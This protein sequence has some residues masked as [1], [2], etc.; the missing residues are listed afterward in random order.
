[1]GGRV[2]AFWRLGTIVLIR[3]DLCLRHMDRIKGA[4]KLRKIPRARSYGELLALR[5]YQYCDGHGADP[6]CGRAIT[7]DIIWG[8]IDAGG[9]GKL[10]P[11]HERQRPSG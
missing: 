4:T 10:W 8:D 2:G 9:A 7:A 3:V 1:M 6:R 11:D 5:V